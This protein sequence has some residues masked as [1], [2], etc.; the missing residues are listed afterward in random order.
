MCST[1]NTRRVR[2]V[3]NQR[4]FHPIHIINPWYIYISVW[5][6]PL[7]NPHMH[8]HICIRYFPPSHLHKTYTYLPTYPLTYI[9][10]PHSSGFSAILLRFKVF[11]LC[12]EGQATCSSTILRLLRPFARTLLVYAA[13]G[14]HSCKFRFSL[15]LLFRGVV[16][17]R[18]V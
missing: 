16:G 18:Y 2:C 9:C 8:V 11:R 3:E 7:L 1:I 13:S 6:S 12:Q 15:L 4:I 14:V 10:K 5:S 17:Y